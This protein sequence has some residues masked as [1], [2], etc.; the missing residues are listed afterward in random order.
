MD[1]FFEKLANSAFPGTSS[2]EHLKLLGK[3]AAGSYMRKEADS[4]TEAVRDA[5]GGEDLNPEQVRRVTEMAN[6]A[7]WRELFHEG[8]NTDTHFDPA[9]A[10]SVLAELSSKPDEVWEDS[11]GL[12]YYNDVPNQTQS[13]DWE[14]AFGV[15]EGTPEYDA[16][17]SGGRESGEVQ[18]V[19]GALDLA[20]YG[21]D[22][23]AGELAMA[24]E[25]FYRMVKQA[26]VTDG[27][28]LL[29]VSQAVGQAVQ[30]PEF[31]IAVMTQAADRLEMEGVRFDR[32]GELQK[33]AHPLVV[34]SE[35]PLM[36]QAAVLEKLAYAH[37][38]A[39]ESHAELQKKHRHATRALRDALRGA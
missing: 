5:V 32:A 17:S 21:V 36:V 39:E 37:Y 4:L 14:E 12:D 30:D 31:A 18:K 27:F 35:H 3:R 20:R 34:N 25:V 11:A 13:V 8:G 28:G 19:A 16:L 15:T 24:G 6:Q 38:R 10:Q 9:D 33:L 2:S 29:Q 1:K 22:Q 7:T 26:H 23:V